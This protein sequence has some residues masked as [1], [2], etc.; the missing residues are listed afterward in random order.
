[1]SQAGDVAQFTTLA[2]LVFHLTGSGLGVSG[3]VAAEIAPV[4]L[5]APAAGAFN[6]TESWAG[7]RWSG[8][9]VGSRPADTAS[10]Y[11]CQPYEPHSNGMSPSRLSVPTVL[12]RP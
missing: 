4:L 12:I 8:C 5:L 6:D 11:T 9:W 3:V 7:W 1:M 10:A 2:L